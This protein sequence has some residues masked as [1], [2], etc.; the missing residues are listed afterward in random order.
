MDETNAVLIIDTDKDKE[1]VLDYL[2]MEYG[3]DIVRLAYTY[4]KDMTLAEDL[5]QEIFIKCYKSLHTFKHQSSYK[6]WLYRIGSNHC[7]DYV[8]SWHHRKVTIAEK[9]SDLLT[10]SNNIDEEIIKKSEDEEL[11]EAI[12]RLEVKY[13]EVIYL[14]YYEEF[15]M[16]EISQAIKINENTVKTRLK[17]A[18]QLLKEMMKEG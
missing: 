18:R 8:K 16:K 17:R 14:H 15:S 12:F 7:K 4:V 5:A 9:L 10:T 3:T 6:T 13:R 1:A 11:V 2:M